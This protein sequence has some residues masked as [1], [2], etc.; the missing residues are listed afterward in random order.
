M[1]SLKSLCR[2]SRWLSLETILEI[3]LFFAKNHVFV[4][5]FQ[6]TDGH[7]DS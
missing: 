3:T 5:A 1:G 2:T 6:V 4:Y 7:R